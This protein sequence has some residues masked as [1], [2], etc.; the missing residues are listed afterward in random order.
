S[1]WS[2][3]RAMVTSDIGIHAQGGVMNRNT[4]FAFCVSAFCVPSAL[5]EDIELLLP[6]DAVTVYLSGAEVT[7]TATVNLPVGDH[8]L[9]MNDL[10]AGI[11]PARL[12]LS[13]EHH[14]VRLGSLQLETVHQGDL[15]S[16]EEQALQ[17]ELDELLDRKAAI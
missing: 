14:D 3:S 6:I 2:G 15:V 17:S 16:A 10:P 7:R 12:L 13:I 8:R 1:E 11:D 9:I 4:A 5:A